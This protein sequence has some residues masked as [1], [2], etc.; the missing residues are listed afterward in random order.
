VFIRFEKL[1]RGTGVGPDKIEG[2]VWVQ[3]RRIGIHSTSHNLEP[4][5]AGILDAGEQLVTYSQ[6][7]CQARPNAPLIGD[8]KRHV[9]VV[10]RV[11]NRSAG[12]EAGS[13]TGHVEC[14][15]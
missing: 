14:V 3:Q 12:Y 8:I 5:P 1:A 2:S 15:L 4:Q 9:V 6:I 11:D 7:K 10:Q 13:L